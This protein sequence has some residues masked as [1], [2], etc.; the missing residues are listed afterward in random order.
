M[1]FSSR[2]G[3]RFFIIKS[4]GSWE[5]GENERKEEIVVLTM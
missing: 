1:M 2:T 5:E 4:E 3:K